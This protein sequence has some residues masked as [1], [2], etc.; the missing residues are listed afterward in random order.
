MVIIDFKV[1]D[2]D[3]MICG[4]IPWIKFHYI[5]NIDRNIKPHEAPY[6]NFCV[7]YENIQTEEDIKLLC[8]QASPFGIHTLEIRVME[9]VLF[10]HPERDEEDEQSLC[11]YF[12]GD[13]IKLHGKVKCVYDV[14]VMS[15][16]NDSNEE[17]DIDEYNCL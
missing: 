8:L 11:V 14:F 4:T 10:S 13:V 2:D 1:D 17:S 9:E 5:E 15:G 7:P 6:E 3:V 16:S 12:H